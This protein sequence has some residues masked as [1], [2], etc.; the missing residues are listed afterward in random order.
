MTTPTDVNP[1][2]APTNDSDL[3]E[4]L[5]TTQDGRF[6]VRLQPDPDPTNPRDDDN[7]LVH[8]I[9]IDTHLG[10]HLPV[11]KNGG[12]LAHAWTRFQGN[13]RKAVDLFT[14]YVTIMH[15]GIVLE[16]A[17]AGGPRSL[18]YVTGEEA[19]AIDNGLLTE[20]YVAAEMQEYEAW[21]GGDV[22]IYIVEER[23]GWTRDDDPD[24]SMNTWEHVDS[25]G[26]LYSTPYAQSQA[27][28]ALAFYT[29][30]PTTPTT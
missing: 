9:T 18:W 1:H 8:V 6:R 20:A 17:P 24:E 4:V 19:Y 27:R 14:R 28:E 5:A 25:C 22:W 21:A 15:D 3:P 12:P 23:V 13:R 7:N 26:N 2:P 10:H 30:R 29:P 16:S 11:D